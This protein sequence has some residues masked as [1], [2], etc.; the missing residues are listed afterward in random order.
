MFQAGLQITGSTSTFVASLADADHAATVL[1]A[2]ALGDLYGM[3]R[4]YLLGLSG[5]IVFS[6]LAPPRRQRQC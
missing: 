4:L 5:V 3:R 1:S 6:V 2:G